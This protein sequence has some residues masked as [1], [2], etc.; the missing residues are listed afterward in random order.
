MLLGHVA[1][2]RPNIPPVG[3]RLFWLPGEGR[4]RRPAV[5]RTEGKGDTLNIFTCHTDSAPET[6]QEFLPDS[7]S[8]MT[9]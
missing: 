5:L 3:M 2:V 8:V 4:P 7:L 6:A 9:G 1:Q